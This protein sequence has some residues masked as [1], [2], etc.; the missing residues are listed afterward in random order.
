MPHPVIDAATAFRQGLINREAS[1]TTALINAYGRAYRAMQGQIQVL[2]QQI[3]QMEQPDRAQVIRLASLRSLTAQV[4]DEVNRF[5]VFADQSIA[6]AV[7]EE[8]VNGLRD[9]RS[10]VEAYFASPQG[11]AAFRAAWDMLP[12]E[13]VEVML[14]YVEE[15]SPLR[16]ALVN[17]LGPAVA[18]RMSNALVDAITLGMNPRRTAA[19]VRRELGVG[20]TWALTTA[21]TAQMWSYREASRA[22]YVANSHIV[23]SWTWWA[24]LDSPRT[25]LSCIAMHG[26]EHPVTEALND[27]YSGRCVALPSLRNARQ[28]GLSQPEVERGESWFNRQSEQAQRQRMGPGMFDAWR[29]GEF[30]FSQLSQRYDDPVYGEML[31]EASLAGLLGDRAR[32]YYAR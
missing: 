15:G 25:C 11:R 18:E 19:L 16:T 31:R 30:R 5:A 21:R 24:S 26:S 4:A 8:I 28:L 13:T 23:E 3:A 6:N 17:R 1:R 22:N 20:L 9:S 27:H 10:T 14:G 32:E 7:S 2:E 12:A 29:A